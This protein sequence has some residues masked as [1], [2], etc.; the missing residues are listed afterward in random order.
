MSNPVAAVLVEW[1]SWLVILTAGYA[2]L[3]FGLDALLTAH[4]RRQQVR[5]QLQA[6]LDQLTRDTAMAV[7]RISAAFSVAQQL[8]RR[9]AAIGRACR[10]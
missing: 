2:A 3:L 5:R 9:E 10:R 7:Q 1:L 4:R 8:I 6:E